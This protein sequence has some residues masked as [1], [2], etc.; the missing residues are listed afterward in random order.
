MAGTGRPRPSSSCRTTWAFVPPKPKPE[1]DAARGVLDLY[2]ESI[3]TR[4]TTV[5]PLV[6]MTTHAQ[7]PRFYGEAVQEIEAAAS[8]QGASG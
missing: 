8:Q 1:T 5:L 3:R 7:Y 6:P 4:K 2:E